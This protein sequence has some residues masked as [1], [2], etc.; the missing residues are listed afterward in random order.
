M[1]QYGWESKISGVSR[2]TRIACAQK[3][4]GTT[5]RSDR[6]RTQGQAARCQQSCTPSY[7]NTLRCILLS[8]PSLLLPLVLL[9]GRVLVSFLSLL[10][11]VRLQRRP[12]TIMQL[13]LSF[14]TLLATI[15]V[16]LSTSE[17]SVQAAPLTRRG[18]SITLPLQRAPQKRGDVHPLV[19]R[20]DQ[21]PCALTRFSSSHH[22]RSSTSSTSTVPTSVLLS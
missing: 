18:K 3:Q 12:V 10:S 6:A 5:G 21:H 17:S 15:L 16:L 22:A 11:I 13:A 7:I 1:G 14:S 2:S 9:Q 19:V 8:S 4:E 20:R